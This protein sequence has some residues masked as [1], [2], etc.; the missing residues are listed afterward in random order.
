RPRSA[1]NLKHTVYFMALVGAIAG[2]ACWNIQAWLS[3]ALTGGQEQNW[4]FV[5]TSA[6]LMGALI[7]GL[8][9][10]FADRWTSER[11]V[12]TWVLAGV[13]AGRSAGVIPGLAYIPIE[14]RV[15]RTATASNSA[16][17]VGRALPWLIAGGLIGLVTGLRWAGANPLRALHAL[18]GGLIGGTLG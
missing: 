2:L 17:L 8:T 7:G 16:I 15:I 11:I 10:A 4:R 13:L 14:S 12:P 3:D 18:L 5:A 1:V 9:V 6:T